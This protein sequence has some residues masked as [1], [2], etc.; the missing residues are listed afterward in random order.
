MASCGEHGAVVRRK[1]GTGSHEKLVR[2]SLVSQSKLQPW[3]NYALPCLATFF[4]LGHATIWHKCNEEYDLI[5]G[6]WI[7]DS[8]KTSRLPFSLLPHIWA[9][10]SE[11]LVLFV[12]TGRRFKPCKPLPTYGNLHPVSQPSKSP[13]RSPF[14]AFSSYNRPAWEPCCALLPGE[15]LVMW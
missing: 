12:D 10:R 2:T 3:Q 1:L 11:S 7:A 4:S 5:F 14:L 6:C 13:S 8:F 9:S 15:T